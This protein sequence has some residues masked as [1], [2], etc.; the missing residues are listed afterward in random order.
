[1]QL[2]QGLKYFFSGFE[3]INQKGLRRFVL[4]PLLINLSIFGSSLFFIYGWLTQGFNY[5]NNLLPQWLNWLEWLMWPIAILVILFSYGMV[6]SV[7]TNFIAAPF[8]GILAEKVELYL[9][10]QR[11]NED[12][13]VDTMRDIPRMLGRELTKLLYYLP[14][15]IGFFI[16]LW[17]LPVVGQVLWVLFSCWMF[18]IQYKDYAFDNHKVSFN[19]M[20]RDLKSRQG[21][22]YG[23]GCAVMLCTAVPILNLIVMP[24]AVCGATKLWVENYRDEYK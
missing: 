3:M 15:A 1:M 8:N 17:I 2:T 12:G 10:G 21:L 24:V 22:S 19:N 9:T 13:L 14:R 7:I 4:I 11:A 16:L 18:A 5:L 23:F 6:F 20:K